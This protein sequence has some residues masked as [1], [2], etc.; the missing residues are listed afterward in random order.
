VSYDIERAKRVLSVRDPMKRLGYSGE[1]LLFA[2]SRACNNVSPRTYDWSVVATDTR[3][4]W[5]DEIMLPRVLWEYAYIADGGGIKPD[6]RNVSGT[7]YIR[8]W[9]KAAENPTPVLD[10]AGE[11]LWRPRVT[12]WAG[13]YGE[14]GHVAAKV[15]NDGGPEAFGAAQY[16][17]QERYDAF[18][19][20]FPDVS[21]CSNSRRV[22]TL[23]ELYDAVFLFQRRDEL[24][25]DCS[26]HLGDDERSAFLNAPSRQLELAEV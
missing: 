6:N 17:R 7:A 19:R 14:E 22:S 13:G 4:S 18:K 23:D 24:P 10:E 9:K 21:P 5:N 11:L 3:H 8:Q 26:F 16:Q 2:I 1:V 15:L 12:V 25:K 20:L